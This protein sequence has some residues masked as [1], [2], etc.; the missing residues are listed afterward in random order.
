MGRRIDLVEAEDL[1]NKM[2]ENL[3][4]SLMLKFSSLLV[5]SS[6]MLKFSSSLLIIIPIFSV[7]SVSLIDYWF[8]IVI[9]DGGDVEVA[10]LPIFGSR[11]RPGSSPECGLIYFLVILSF[12]ESHNYAGKSM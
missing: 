10:P 8:L 2:S 9:S 6:S 11:E 1:V 12:V 4:F 3:S 5:I 7:F